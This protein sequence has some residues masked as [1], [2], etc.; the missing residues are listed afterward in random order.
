[1]T[2]RDDDLYWRWVE[3]GAPSSGARF[4]VMVFLDDLGEKPWK[5]PSTPYLNEQPISEVREA[6]LHVPGENRPVVV[7]YRQFYPEPGDEP[8]V[9][10]VR[11]SQR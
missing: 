5:V 9:V 1:M 2:L 11:I 4:E 8:L 7:H 10:L 6:I 3:R